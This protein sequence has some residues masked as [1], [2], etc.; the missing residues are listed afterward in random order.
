MRC[1]KIDELP[2]PP[3]GKVGWPW[4][5]DSPQL[6]NR[7]PD[8]SLWPRISIVT[9][10]LNQGQFI[11]ET[12]RSILLQG[13]PN[14]E[15]IIIDGGSSDGSVETII[16]YEKWLTYWI[17]EP[18]R[19]QSHAI[20]KGFF[21]A[22]GDILGWLNSDDIYKINALKQ[23]CI[24]YKSNQGNIIAGNV[25]NFDNEIEKET[26]IYQSDVTLENLV[27]FWESK[28][29]WHQ[30]GI[31]FPRSIYEMGGGIDE[32][33]RFYMDHDLFCRLLQYCKVIYIEDIV[34][35]FR[36]HGASKTCSIFDYML[37]ELSLVSKRYWP[38]IPSM[39][40]VLANKRIG[41]MYA[42]SFMDRLHRKQ[43]IPALNILKSALKNNS[44]EVTHALLS[45]FRNKFTRL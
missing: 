41:E 14:L 12:I 30:P 22:T 29:S 23:V 17:S 4:T 35:C 40:A 26:I 24:T 6:Q 32:T 11:E 8:D 18:D 45:I 5:E 9:P 15:Y 44:Q 38:L 28:Y 3:T 36:L 20:K 34:A 37:E 16:K 27:K 39:N 19:G 1:P 21:K 25:I 33:L 43:L 13:Y 42:R 7:M 10:S 2:S 31:F